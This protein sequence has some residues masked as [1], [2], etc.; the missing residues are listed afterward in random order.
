MMQEL[1]EGR[2]STPPVAYSLRYLAGLLRFHRREMV[3]AQ[4]L[5]V[6][7]TLLA[8][9]LPLLMPL[10]VDEV[11]LQQPG[12]LVPLVQSY[13]PAFWH[14]PTLYILAILMIAVSLRTASVGLNILQSREFTVIAKSMVYLLRRQLL[15]RLQ[16]LTLS[17]YETIGSG[18]I[19]AHMITDLQT[20]DDFISTTVGKFMIAVLTIVG[21]AAV[22]LWLHW[23]LAL[24]ILC[25]NPVVIYFTMAL[26]RRVKSSKGQE[27]RAIELFQ[28]ALT[29]TLDGIHQVRAYNREQHY[30]SR[31]VEEARKVRQRSAAWAWKS[32]LAARASAGVFLL[33]FDVFRAVSM[34]MVVFSDLSVGEMMA[35]FGYLWFMITPVQDLM[36]VQYAYY[37]A[38]AA[39]ERLNTLLRLKVEPTAKHLANPFKEALTTSVDIEEVH[40]EFVAQEPV[41]QGISLHIEAG[42]KVA[43]VGAS[44]AGKSTLM[45]VLLGLYP[46]NR[47]RVD[48]GGVP[49]DDIGF[50]VVRENVGIVLQQPVIFSDTVRNNLTM[51]RKRMDEDLWA[52]LDIAQL[53]D[54]FKR[55]PKQLS[56]ELGVR[57]IRLSGGQRQ[58]LAIARMILLDPKVLI[59]DESTSML[60]TETEARLQ[61]RLFQHF[62]GRTTLIVA[63]RLSAVKPADH[64]YVMEDGRIAEQGGHQQLLG[65]KGL[66]AKLY[67]EQ[68]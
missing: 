34:L 12:T 7:A 50:D 52:A 49:A 29:E 61:E 56:T 18:S 23:E 22:L 10:L 39:M 4:I 66:Y 5:A 24:F 62:T 40:F 64:V 67:G 63:H 33:G 32:D 65:Q 35:V 45:Q 57:G 17:E 51:E 58:R 14:G 59:L 31:V 36:N 11:L 26:G 3:L 25:M 41:L 28:Q 46:L 30:L 47:G 27:N 54:L 20:V 21:T 42:E 13:T 60:D 1:P 9:P 38:G 6:F 43:F 37:A 16:R 19:T 2:S 48:Y 53:G 8:I 55:A 15:E 68:S 44:G